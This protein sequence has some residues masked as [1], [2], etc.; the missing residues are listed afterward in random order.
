MATNKKAPLIARLN[1]GAQTRVNAAGIHTSARTD[2]SPK[3]ERETRI[4]E[5]F[6]YAKRKLILVGVESEAQ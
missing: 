3:G 1:V 4:I 6:G 5:Q 2:D